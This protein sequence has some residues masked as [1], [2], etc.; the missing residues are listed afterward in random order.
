MCHD[1]FC[2]AEEKSATNWNYL[3]YYMK[4]HPGSATIVDGWNPASTSWA[5]LDSVSH[6]LCCFC[7]TSFGFLFA[8]G[9]SLPSNSTTKN[10]PNF[11]LNK[12]SSQLT[13]FGSNAV[14]IHPWKPTYA[15]NID[16]W[17]MKLPVKMIPILKDIL[18]FAGFCWGS[19]AAYVS[20]PKLSAQKK[21]SPNP[22]HPGESKANLIRT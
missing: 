6:C 11:C 18:I 19:G 5:E 12:S 16:G 13:L 22:P 17:K 8:P 15:M 21:K 20:N 1:G 2:L 9:F 7:W 3:G 14:G 4:D 10:K